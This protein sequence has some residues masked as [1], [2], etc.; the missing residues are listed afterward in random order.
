MILFNEFDFGLV[1]VLKLGLKTVK[2]NLTYPF[3]FDELVLKNLIFRS[4]KIVAIIEIL[5]ELLL[6]D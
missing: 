5:F 4:K 6:L 1:N 2:F 3:H